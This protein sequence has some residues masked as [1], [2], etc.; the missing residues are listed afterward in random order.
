[1]NMLLHLAVALMASMVSAYSNGAAAG[2]CGFTDPNGG[3][4][5]GAGS[6]SHG[7]RTAGNGMFD[8]MIESTADRWR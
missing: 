8:L 5:G 2:A 3:N 4:P 7:T 1:M 6:T